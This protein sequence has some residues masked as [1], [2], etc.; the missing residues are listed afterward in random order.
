MLDEALEAL[1]DALELLVPE[2]F[3]VTFAVVAERVVVADA[4]QLP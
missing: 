1:D 4:V 2:A 3:D